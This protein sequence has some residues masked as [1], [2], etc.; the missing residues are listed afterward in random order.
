MLMHLSCVS[1]ASCHSSRDT[2]CGIACSNEGEMLMTKP[3][4]L[5]VE[6]KASVRQRL[7][8]LMVP[9]G[10][11]VEAQEPSDAIG[12]FRHQSPDLILVNASLQGAHDGL[13]LA[14]HIRN[15]HHTMPLILLTANGSE[16][17]A[18]AALRAGVNDYVK[19][20]VAPE[21]LLSR[22]RI[23]LSSLRR[24]SVSV[25]GEMTAEGPPTA[26]TWWVTAH[27]CNRSKLTSKKS[28]P[29]IVTSSSPARLA[30]ARS[31]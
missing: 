1:A 2:A 20:P 26:H 10:S 13:A 21:E 25:P 14:Q 18:I 3:A 12:L 27:R 17:L 22:V 23:Q 24:P 5:I 7:K 9:Y 30:P 29:Q 8:T 4:I 11:V 19:L 16:E 15:Q 31:S 28:A 6:P